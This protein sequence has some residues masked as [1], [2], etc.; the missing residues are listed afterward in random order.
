MLTTIIIL[1]GAATVWAIVSIIFHGSRP[2]RS[3]SWV[4]TILFLPLVG[5]LLYYLFGVNRRKFKFYKLRSGLKRK[6][7]DKTY[8]ASMITEFDERL[9]TSKIDRLAKMLSNSSHN[10]P[11]PGNKVRVLH[12]GRKT[13]ECIFDAIKEAKEFIHVQYYIFEKGELQDE[14]HRLFEEKIKEGVEIRLIYDSL[15]SM[16]FKG[17]LKKRFRR[18]GVD[19]YPMMPLRIGSFMYTLNYRNHRKIVVI[20]GK[21]GFVGGMNVSDKYIEAESELGVWEDIHL[22]VEGPAVASLH[23]IFIKDYHFAS[24]EPPLLQPKYLPEL[25]EIGDAVVQ[26]NASGPDSDQ[27]SILHQYVGMCQSAEKCL[28]IANP[29]FIPGPTLLTVIKMAALSGVQVKLLV[30]KKSDSFLAKYSMHANFEVL[31]EVGVEI[32]LRNDFSHSKLIILDDKLSSIGTGNFDHRSFE[33]NFETNALVYDQ[34]ITE[35]IIKV[36]D[37]ECEEASRLEY[38]EFKKR[39]RLQKFKEGFAKFFSP[40]L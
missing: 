29:Y 31:L 24:Q 39:S 32:F 20:D 1:Y 3:V 8:G 34:T 19:T 22:K 16:S 7:Y 30:P 33:Y 36:F 27:P 37:K 25:D 15:G 9:A 23:R 17:K 4:L 18:I 13:F 10:A 5:P 14:F 2:S 40:L 6:L 12:A 26:L 11:F 28:R 21:V 38:E 35:D